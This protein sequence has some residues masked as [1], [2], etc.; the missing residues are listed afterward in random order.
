VFGLDAL[1]GYPG[2]MFDL[3]GSGPSG[4]AGKAGGGKEKALIW[5]DVVRSQGRPAV[6]QRGAAGLLPR[7]NRDMRP[8]EQKNGRT[9]QAGCG[10]NF[11]PVIKDQ[12]VGVLPWM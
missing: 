8:S 7:S 4:F 1:Q 2:Q 5:G 10:L 6:Y 12:S 11:Y 3:S 9:L